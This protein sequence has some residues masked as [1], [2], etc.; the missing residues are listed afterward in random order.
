MEQYLLFHFFTGM[1]GEWQ[2][3]FYD[4]R[5][6]CIFLHWMNFKGKKRNMQ[7]YIS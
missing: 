5:T 2:I 4:Y 1:K 3:K 7:N 6:P